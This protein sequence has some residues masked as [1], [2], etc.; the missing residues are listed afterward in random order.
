MCT[1]YYLACFDSFTGHMEAARTHLR[2]FR[3]LADERGGLKNLSW[4]LKCEVI[5]IDLFIARN[6]LS[7]PV[8]EVAEYDPGSFWERMTPEE[9]KALM[10]DY[11]LSK[12]KLDDLSSP[13]TEYIYCG[14]CEFLA[15]HDLVGK[16]EDTTRRTKILLWTHMRKYALAA[17]VLDMRL[18][19][20]CH[21]RR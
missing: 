21:L 11:G 5:A 3:S 10:Q 15:V 13:Y 8:F 1:A 2:G 19:L 4:P 18:Q 17:H 12:E 7:D 6:S 9:R 16:T 20:G 14:Y